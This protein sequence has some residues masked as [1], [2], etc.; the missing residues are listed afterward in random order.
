[1]KRYIS[2]GRKEDLLKEKAEW[3]MKYDARNQLYKD[4]EQ[5]YDNARWNWIDN[6][7]S[8]ITKQ[9]QS[10]IDKLPGLKI[11][12]DR[13]WGSVQVNFNYEDRWGESRDNKSLLWS[14]EVSLKDNGEIKKESNSWSGFQAVTPAQIDD[15]LNSANFL[16]AIVD[17]DWAPVLE[18]AKSSMPKY[19]QYVG[20]KNP[21]YDEEYKDPGYD[22]MIREAEVEEATQSGKWIKSI[23]QY[24]YPQWYFI[25]SETPKYYNVVRVSETDLRRVG[26]DSQ[27]YPEYAKRIK[28]PQNASSYW[29]DRIK[30]DNIQFAN[31]IETKTADELLQ[32]AGTA[33]R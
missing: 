23:G 24:G 33:L 9:F 18:E 8:I 2:A 20:V 26:P 6:L 32:L 15:L 7:V 21:N 1:M 31:P 5:N 28:N 25:V 11:T 12:A 3:K 22:K 10:Y 19:S 14:Y 30:K 27:Y 29:V 17:F 13:S 4:Q 16:K